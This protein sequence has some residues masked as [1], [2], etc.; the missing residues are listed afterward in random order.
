MGT[1]GRINYNPVIAYRQL[2]YAMDGPPK[3][4]EVTESV[5]FVRGGNPEMLKRMKNAWKGIHQKD[6]TTLSN[7]VPIARIPYMEWIQDKVKTL[8]FPF[9]RSAPLYEQPP[10]V[11]NDIMPTEIFTQVHVENIQLHSKDRKAWMKFYWV[12]K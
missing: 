12:D 4:E 8:Q 1:N 10:V 6:I 11:L 3:D 5:Y 2:G 7:K 9:A